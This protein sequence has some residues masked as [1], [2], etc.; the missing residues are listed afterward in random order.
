MAVEDQSQGLYTIAILL[1]PELSE[2]APA[3]SLRIPLK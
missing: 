2:E 1:M 3:W